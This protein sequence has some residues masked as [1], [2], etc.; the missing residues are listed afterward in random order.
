MVMDH[1]MRV[2]GSKASKM[3]KD[4]LLIRQE[5]SK[6]VLGKMGFFS[7]EC[8]DFNIDIWYYIINL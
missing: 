4:S 6:K 5:G 3:V 1:T 7:I 2:L 8:D